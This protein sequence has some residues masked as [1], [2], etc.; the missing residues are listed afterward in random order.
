[1]ARKALA[2]WLGADFGTALP[3]DADFEVGG[4]RLFLPSD[5]AGSLAETAGCRCIV[6]Y[7]DGP[8]EGGSMG[9]EGQAP[10]APIRRGNKAVLADR[11]VANIVFNE[12]C[13]ILRPRDR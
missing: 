3:I 5:P 7:Q 12:Y 1:M 8:P 13:I 4:E 10:A 11:E 6:E 9:G 2:P